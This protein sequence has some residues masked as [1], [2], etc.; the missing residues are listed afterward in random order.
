[1]SQQCLTQHERQSP[2]RPARACRAVVSVADQIRPGLESQAASCR[3]RFTP[4]AIVSSHRVER[5][6]LSA[7]IRPTQRTPGDGLLL[8]TEWL[9]AARDVLA[10]LGRGT[11]QQ[12]GKKPHQA[13]DTEYLEQGAHRHPR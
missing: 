4:E 2:S 7:E 12:C 8:A 1:M 13:P 5:V 6:M 9:A 11:K 10:V 3:L